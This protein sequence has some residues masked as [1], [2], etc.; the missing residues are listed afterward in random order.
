MMQF[1]TAGFRFSAYGQ[2]LYLEAFIMRSP[3][4]GKPR[5]LSGRPASS[6]FTLVELLVVM[7]IIAML[8]AM[9]LPAVQYGREAARRATC[10]NNLKQMGLA[11]QQHESAW[12]FFPT[13]GWGW[14]WIG[15]ADRGF[16]KKQ[17]GG[18]I[19]NL[20]PYMDQKAL[21]DLGK[22]LPYGKETAMTLAN[23]SPPAD[24]QA[25][26]VLMARTP[27]SIM[28]CPSRRRSILYPM[29]YSGADVG[30]CGN[31]GMIT[32]PAAQN[33]VA[34][35]DYAANDGSDNVDQ[36]WGGPGTLAAGDDPTCSWP[37]M[38]AGAVRQ[39]GVVYQRSQVSLAMIPDGASFTIFAG[40]KY[41]DPDLYSTGLSGADNENMY[42]GFDNDTNR[43]TSASPIQ[44]TPGLDDGSHFGSAHAA[45]AQFVMCDGSV[46]RLSF[47]ID[48]QVFAWLGQRDDT[49]QLG[50]NYTPVNGGSPIPHTIDPSKLF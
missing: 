20:L 1:G 14:W 33:F 49:A 5:G 28:N 9:T 7:T 31:V 36:W 24:K 4:F 41:L 29:S 30:Y 8:V 43:S 48:P 37:D 35:T 17:P 45:G 32:V 47:T 2:R 44:D 15:D 21:H 50:R 26:L 27:L 42:V 13:G 12:G 23:L 6:G 39:N 10:M 25:A 16:T 46:R 11:A 19:Y 38:A 3:V 22:G 40:E 34:R 18:W